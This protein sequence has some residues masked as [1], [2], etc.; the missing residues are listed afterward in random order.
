MSLTNIVVETPTSKPFY[1]YQ[2]EFALCES[3]FWSAISLYSALKEQQHG[4]ITTATILVLI[5]Q[6]K[7]VQCAIKIV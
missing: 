5:T 6:F 3:C 1:R 7:Y 4:E 2:R